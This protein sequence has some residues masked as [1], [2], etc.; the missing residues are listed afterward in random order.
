MPTSVKTNE[1]EKEEW[2]KQWEANEFLSGAHLPRK[3]HHKWFAGSISNSQRLE[4]KYVSLPVPHRRNRALWGTC[5]KNSCIS[6]CPIYHTVTAT[7]WYWETRA[8][9]GLASKGKANYTKCVYVVVVIVVVVVGGVCSSV[10][11][12]TLPITLANKFGRIHGIDKIAHNRWE[13]KERW[14]TKVI[15]H[16]LSYKENGGKMYT[17]PRNALYLMH[18]F[19]DVL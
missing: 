17:I 12:C 8:T 11:N 7:L 15:P 13:E 9:S 2:S 4:R 19:W 16:I 14:V 1:R 3:L 10:R 6:N 5:P 18:C